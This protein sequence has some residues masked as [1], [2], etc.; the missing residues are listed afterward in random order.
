MTRRK[1]KLAPDW[2]ATPN[3]PTPGDLTA[4]KSSAIHHSIFTS[5]GIRWIQLLL[6]FP[7][8][9]PHRGLFFVYSI[10][11]KQQDDPGHRRKDKRLEQSD[12]YGGD[13]DCQC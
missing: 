5:I 13:K 3:L 7:A 9:T 6:C 10:R 1:L 11:M 8:R 12:D 2:P 4:S